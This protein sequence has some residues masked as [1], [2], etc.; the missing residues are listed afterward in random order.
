MLEKLIQA[1]T[2][3]LVANT[4][5]MIAIATA[6]GAKQ[7]KAATETPAPR[8]RAAKQ[9]AD[10][11]APAAAAKGKTAVTV[12]TVSELVLSV[13]EMAGRQIAVGILG[14]FKAKKV[15]DV[16]PK[17]FPALAKKLKAALVQAKADAETDPADDL[18]DDFMDGLEDDVLEDDNLDDDFD[19]PED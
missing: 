9:V 18:E 8:R 5:A 13:A 1:N 6:G 15:K 17:Q 14:E 19:F 12:K 7:G 4:A 10:A 3:A 11:P 2:E 16:P